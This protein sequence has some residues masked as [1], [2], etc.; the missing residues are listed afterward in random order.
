MNNARAAQVPENPRQPRRSENRANWLP[1]IDPGQVWIF[2]GGIYSRNRLRQHARLKLRLLWYC[3]YYSVN[4]TQITDSRL[5]S[6]YHQV[7][8]LEPK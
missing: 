8:R 4:D 5:V 1:C 2:L 7:R 6:D 3:P